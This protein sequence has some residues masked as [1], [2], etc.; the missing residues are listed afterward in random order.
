MIKISKNNNSLKQEFHLV[1]SLMALFVTKFSLRVFR[2]FSYMES[3][4]FGKVAKFRYTCMRDVYGLGA[5][6]N[7]VVPCLL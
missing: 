2:D 4:L 5:G 7:L 3:S 6:W 1:D